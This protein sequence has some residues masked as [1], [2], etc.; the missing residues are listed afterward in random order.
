MACNTT[1]T[2]S[3][4]YRESLNSSSSNQCH[5]CLCIT[6]HHQLLFL[7]VDLNFHSVLSLALAL[8]THLTSSTCTQTRLRASLTTSATILSKMHQLQHLPLL[9]TTP[10]TI[11]S[12]SSPI[13]WITSAAAPLSITHTHNNPTTNNQ[14]RTT[15]IKRTRTPMPNKVKFSHP[16]EIDT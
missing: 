14:T 6:N 7:V 2:S 16:F 11:T 8:P 1:S 15:T 9:L 5:R 10:P 3:H 13:A 12:T 4:K